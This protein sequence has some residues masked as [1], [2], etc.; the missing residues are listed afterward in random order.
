MAR[1]AKRPPRGAEV[2]EEG[3]R[4]LHLKG[5]YPEVLPV[6][7][8]IGVR[9]VPHIPHSL[10][11]EASRRMAQDWMALAR[12]EGLG[13]EVDW[14][15]EMLGWAMEWSVLHGIAEVRT[16]YFKVATN[17]IAS[18]EKW[19]VRLEGN[20]PEDAPRGLSYPYR[21]PAK[22]SRTTQRSSRWKTGRAEKKPRGT[23]GLL[24]S[25]GPTPHPSAIH[26]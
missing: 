3:P 15:Y 21:A 7:R 16:P 24:P 26:A 13:E 17:S 8:Y 23:P 25:S 4:L 12:E 6:L 11:C 20:V 2:V 14:A 18:K 10:R 9:L 1:S 5:H 19:T 22:H